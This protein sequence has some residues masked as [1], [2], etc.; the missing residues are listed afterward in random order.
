MLTSL[1][2]LGKA[3]PVVSNF[4]AAQTIKKL[5]PKWPGEESWENWDSKRGAVAG[6]QAKGDVNV[7]LQPRNSFG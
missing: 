3:D 6:Q 2:S 5:K 1:T 7:A 4:Q